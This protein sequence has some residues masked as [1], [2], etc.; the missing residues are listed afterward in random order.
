MRTGRRFSWALLALL[1]VVALLTAMFRFA[2]ARPVQRNLIVELDGL[3]PGSRPLKIALLSD[4]HVAKLG[5]TPSRLRETV[6]RVTALRPDLILVGGDFSADKLLGAYDV[7]DAVGPLVGLKARLGV[8]AV[9]GNHDNGDA[10]SFRA[11]LEQAG[12]QLLDNSASRAGP[13]TIVGVSGFTRFIRAD[14]IAAA[15][16]REGGVPVVLT[17]GPDLIPRLPS[18][19]EL[20]MA[21][22]THCGQIV[23]PLIGPLET[24]SRYGR[25]YACGVVREGRRVSVITGGLG[26]SGLPLRLNAPPDF[27]MITVVPPKK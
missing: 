27:W 5:D 3:A 25:R 14:W 23:L 17:H 13:L 4:L 15:I 21:G 22:H 8:F 2:E 1:P 20:A 10:K 9:L 12:V 11:V 18:N 26:V 19:V 6:S 16:R 7:E 24:R